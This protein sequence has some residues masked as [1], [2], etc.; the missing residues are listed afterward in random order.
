MVR[1]RLLLLEVGR[2]MVPSKGR[3]ESSRRALYRWPLV[4]RMEEGETF[5]LRVSTPRG[6]KLGLNTDVGRGSGSLSNILSFCLGVSELGSGENG[7]K[8]EE[9]P[10]LKEL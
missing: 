9:N 2:E 7:E 4:G 6:P 10:G 5:R 3:E 8:V 1:S